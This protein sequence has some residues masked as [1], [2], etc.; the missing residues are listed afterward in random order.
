MK[1]LSQII[2]L[3]CFLN[4]SRGCSLALIFM[5][6]KHPRG[7]VV[8][9]VPK[10]GFEG[11]AVYTLE[12]LEQASSTEHSATPTHAPTSQPTAD[13]AV[14]CDDAAPNAVNDGGGELAAQGGTDWTGYPSNV[15]ITTTH[16][17][18]GGAVFVV[19][20]KSSSGTPYRIS[21]TVNVPVGAQTVTISTQVCMHV[22]PPSLT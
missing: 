6:A 5:L 7:Q 20:P 13:G 22:H 8:T 9:F 18:V 2:E 3:C 11:P 12:V 14:Q 16:Q 1:Y 10:Q 15:P 19:D 21:Q 17:S 4:L